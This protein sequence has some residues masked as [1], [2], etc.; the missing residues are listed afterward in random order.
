MVG[1]SLDANKR[2]IAG[3]MTSAT[4]SR[5]YKFANREP[6]PLAH[7][8]RGIQCEMS[9]IRPLRDAL[10]LLVFVELVQEPVDI[11]FLQVVWRRQPQLVRVAAADADLVCLPHP[12]L[13]FHP[14][15]GRHIDAHNRTPKSRIWRRP[16]LGATLFHL[17]KDVV[18]QLSVTVFD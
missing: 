2:S 18:G 1:V 13:Q 8:K 4:L 5:D 12:V 7:R 14:R 17:S 9:P 3:M 11:F 6:G 16:R 15:N 10:A